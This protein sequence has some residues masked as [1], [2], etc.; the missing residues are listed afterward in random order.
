M[1]KTSLKLGKYTGLVKKKKACF[2]GRIVKI[3]KDGDFLE[4]PVE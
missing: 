3:G 4:G 1:Q 2:C